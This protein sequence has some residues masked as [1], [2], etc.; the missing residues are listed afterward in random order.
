MAEEDPDP[1]GHAICSAPALSDCGTVN[2][3]SAQVGV[4][5][6]GIGRANTLSLLDS[7]AV[8]NGMTFAFRSCIGWPKLERYRLDVA[9]APQEKTFQSAMIGTVGVVASFVP[10]QS[11]RAARVDPLV[12]LRHE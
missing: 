10:S 5:Q 2:P 12:A 1:R 9:S 7:V 4:V 8:A 6:T 3:K 11:R